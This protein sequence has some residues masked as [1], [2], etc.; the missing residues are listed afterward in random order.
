MR[1]DA[2]KFI[3]RRPGVVDDLWLRCRLGQGGRG[4][5]CGCADYAA[6]FVGVLEHGPADRGQSG[7]LGNIARRDI[8]DLHAPL[9]I[10]A[11]RSL[12]VGGATQATERER[13]ARSAPRD[14]RPPLRT[15]AVWVV[16]ADDGERCTAMEHRKN[17]GGHAAG[18]KAVGGRAARQSG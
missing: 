11:Y 13:L 14:L 9:R 8:A 3:A 1:E 6:P 16:G 10:D 7:H 5:V 2:T 15:P 12:A 17:I 4:P 18:R